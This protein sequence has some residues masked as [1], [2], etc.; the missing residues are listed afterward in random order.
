MSYKI[1]KSQVQQWWTSVAN[2]F[3]LPWWIE[4][5]T[6]VPSCI[7]FFGPFDN[8]REAKRLQD[9][10]IEDLVAEK[11]FGVTVE[12]KQCQPKLLTVFDK[13]KLQKS[14]NHIDIHNKST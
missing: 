4:I 8:F 1:S 6:T 9:G 7:Y 12:V 5:K 2:R 10:Y 3:N 13:S 14:S 11:A